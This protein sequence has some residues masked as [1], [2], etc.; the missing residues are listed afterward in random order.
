VP[1]TTRHPLRVRPAHP[2]HG[3]PPSRPR[4]TADRFWRILQGNQTRANSESLAFRRDHRWYF[5]VGPLS[6]PE[7]GFFM[8]GTVTPSLVQ[9]FASMKP[10]DFGRTI[11][12][13]W[14]VGQRP[15]KEI[16]VAVEKEHLTPLDRSSPRITQPPGSSS[17]RRRPWKADDGNA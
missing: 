17:N 11:E 10:A 15:V 1:V 3:V 7:G 5:A 6:D 13:K 9:Q 2:R 16:Q 8:A 4:R 12:P 14:Q